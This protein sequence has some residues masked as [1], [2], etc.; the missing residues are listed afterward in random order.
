MRTIISCPTCARTHG[1]L[2]PFAKEVESMTADLKKPI[3]IAVMGCEVNGPGEAKAADLG[4]AMTKSG[5]VIF[6]KGK[7]IGQFPKGSLLC[8]FK[9]ELNRL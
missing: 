8:A 1:E 7:S 2:I 5:G 4:V 3:T 6:K 9:K